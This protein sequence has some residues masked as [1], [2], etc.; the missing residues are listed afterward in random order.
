VS[1]EETK[2]GTC[3][4]CGEIDP[5]GNYGELGT[6]YSSHWYCS[7][8]FKDW[9][10]A[11]GVEHLFEHSQALKVEKQMLLRQ[12]TRQI[13]ERVAEDVALIAVTQETSPFSPEDPQA[14]PKLQQA[15]QLEQVQQSPSP[16]EIRKLKKDNTSKD[17]QQ[18]TT[19]KVQGQKSSRRRSRKDSSSG[20]S[21]KPTE[22][23]T[24]LV[25]TK[26]QDC[27]AKAEGREPEIV[28]R[29]AVS[30]AS[31]TQKDATWSVPLQREADAEDVKDPMVIWKKE[32]ALAEAIEIT[33]EASNSEYYEY[34]A[35]EYYIGSDASAEDEGDV[36]QDFELD[37]A[38]LEQHTISIRRQIGLDC[39]GRCGDNV[40][41]DNSYGGCGTCISAVPPFEKLRS[42]P[43]SLKPHT[44]MDS[45]AGLMSPY[46]STG[47]IWELVGGA[48]MGGIVA[49]KGYSLE[50]PET[51]PSRLA[52]R[53]L[54]EELR[55]KGSRLQFLLID[56]E[57]PNIGWV[58]FKKNGRDLLVMRRALT[59]NSIQDG[60]FTA[61]AP[62][63]SAQCLMMPPYTI[64]EDDSEDVSTTVGSVVSRGSNM[65][66]VFE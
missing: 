29:C 60:K 19:E 21:E 14:S 65:L 2:W 31:T 8:C 24:W 32:G 28:G 41:S 36:K 12:E 23:A 39:R 53:A 7:D 27:A 38:W 50:S 35:S 51:S 6:E 15:P 64:V 66:G 49:R 45:K 54:V 18:D 55:I 1:D 34:A 58:S 9:D 11:K 47:R 56:G 10:E 25:P 40:V 61:S 17:K 62:V 20:G 37:V 42:S 3:K 26:S 30:D 46:A 63:L 13:Q 22:G 57:G 43:K 44:C 33:T 4:Y 16:Q 59:V 52:S 5:S 48:R